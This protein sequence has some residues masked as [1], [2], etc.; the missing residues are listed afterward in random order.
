MKIFITGCAKSGTTL[1]RR[2][3]NAYDL[4]VAVD[5][6]S[7][8]DFVRSDYDV[9]KRNASAIL[10]NTINSEAQHN[11]RKLILENDIKIVNLTRNREDVLRSENGYVTEARYQA[12]VSQF[13]KHRDLIDINVEFE[14]LIRY[15]DDVQWEVSDRF[16]LTPEFMFS[17]Y[18]TFIDPIKEKFKD[19][20][21]SL[22]RLG[23]DYTK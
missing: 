2:L 13:Y 4:R 9:A 12:C 18:P 20:N 10:S 16:G 22:R 7:L 21:Y 8:E 14:K 3:F 6:M 5:E 1:M 11:Q 15:P 23:E 19:G 17:D